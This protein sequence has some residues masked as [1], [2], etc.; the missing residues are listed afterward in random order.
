LSTVTVCP[1]AVESVKLDVDTLS[2]VPAAPPAA[3]PDRALDPPPGGADRPE[4]AAGE[5]AV[6]AVAEPVPAV[7]LT[8][9]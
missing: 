9:P 5:L 1:V 2:T 6:V 4:I 7:A 8:M 3:G